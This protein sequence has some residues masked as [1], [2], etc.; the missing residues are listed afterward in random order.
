MLG[1]EKMDRIE[2]DVLIIGA[3]PAGL[4]AAM[5]TARRKL[6]TI[7]VEKALPGGQMQ[8]TMDIENYPGFEKING[9]E[10]AEKMKKQAEKFG[11]K[12]EYDMITKVSVEGNI[13][14]AVGNSKEYKAK[15]MI[16]ATG[17]EHRHLKVPGEQELAGKGV[18]YCATC[19]ALFYKGKEVAVIGGG[20]SAVEDAIYLSGVAE[21]VHLIHRRNEFR[22]DPDR[23][24]KMKELGVDI[25]TPKSPAKFEKT[26][27]GKVKITFNEGGEI[28]VDGVFI[29]VGYI[30]SAEVFKGTNLEFTKSG[31]IK[32]DEQQRTNLPGV[33]AAG[34][35]TGRL[36]QIAVAV[37]E[38]A[39]AGMNAYKYIQKPYWS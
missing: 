36:A 12:I 25:I 29:S 4:T 26:E 18:S 24:E 6:N 11:A 14:K 32:V 3:G 33:F 23:V 7:V 35:I 30:P 20:N 9:P 16:I 27:E 21:K 13:I 38:G 1:D 28:E 2:C 19:D 15:T 37:G 39:L 34:D 5:Y 8:L 22:A 17:G 10:L 31:H